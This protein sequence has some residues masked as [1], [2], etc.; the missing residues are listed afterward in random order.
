VGFVGGGA[1]NTPVE[2]VVDVGR[3][4]AGNV[5]GV[6]DGSGGGG[7]VLCGDVERVVGREGPGGRE[8]G[9]CRKS[10]CVEFGNAGVLGDV[11]PGVV[12]ASM[13][14]RGVC[15]ARAEFTGS[16]VGV[17]GG[18]WGSVE[19]G[20]SWAV[21]CGGVLSVVVVDGAVGWCLC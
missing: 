10:L 6:L 14:R 5:A 8:V 15:T 4:G 9:V 16:G 20:S 3:G 7:G 11:G 19:G 12:D 17:F 13:G 21:C 1:K 18:H 2:S